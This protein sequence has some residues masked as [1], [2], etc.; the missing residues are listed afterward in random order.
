[1]E[2]DI[3]FFNKIKKYQKLLQEKKCRLFIYFLNCSFGFLEKFPY[4]FIFKTFLSKKKLHNMATE[5][6]FYVL[7]LA[8]YFIEI[9]YCQDHCH[10]V[11][12]HGFP[13]TFSEKSGFSS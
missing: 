7:V 11:I 1:M 6:F 2:A 13:W 3:Y 8:F 12:F 9:Q 5:Y 10:T 4:S